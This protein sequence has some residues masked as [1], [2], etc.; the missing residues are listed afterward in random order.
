MNED[1]LSLLNKAYFF[2]KFRP[3]SEKEV[4]DYLYKKIKSKHWSRDDA[5]KVIEELKE[6]ELIDDEK[7]VDWFVRN[8]TTLKPKGQRL[9]TR[10]LKL[11]GISDELIEKYFLENT[12]DEE[13]LAFKI[14]EKRW[15]RYKSLSSQKRFEKACRFLMS[16]GFNYDLT[17]KTIADLTNKE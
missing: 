9:L 14:L 16:R 8:R 3:R 7:F 13:S 10:E 12:I 4:R 2:L 6:E 17:K 15:P 11:K 1:L 5:E